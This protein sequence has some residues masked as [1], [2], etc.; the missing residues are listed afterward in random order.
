MTEPCFGCLSNTQYPQLTHLIEINAPV[1]DIFNC[2]NELRVIHKEL[3]PWS[4]QTIKEHFKYHMIPPVHIG[5]FICSKNPVN[6]NV[7]SQILYM[8]NTMIRKMDIIALSIMVSD[9][10]Q[11]MRL[12][13][14]KLPSWSERDVL[15][16][17]RNHKYK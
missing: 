6:K 3:P 10:Y 17:F 8:I 9:Y 16:H 12:D 14:N 1:E 15:E 2:Y 7:H 11:D 5:C 13:D 4:T